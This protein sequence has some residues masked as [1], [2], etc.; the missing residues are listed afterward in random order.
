MTLAEP[1]LPR[2]SRKSGTSRFSEV[3]LIADPLYGYIEITRRRAGETSE[4][5]LILSPW[6]QR[7][8]R[9]R[10]LQS[11][12]WVFPSA[13][14]SRYVHLLGA[15]HLASMF[16]RRIDTSLRAAFSDAP[17][18]ACVEE[19]LRIAGLLH[20]VGHGPF[21]HFFDQ[22][23][24]HQWKINHEDIGRQII[25]DHL[26]EI[27]SSLRSSPSGRFESGESIDPMWV[28]WVMADAEIPGYKPPAWLKACKP[29][30]CGPATVDN[31]DYVPRD[32]HMCG[33][34]LG[35]VDI[36]RLIHYTFVSDKGLVLHSHASGALEMFLASRLYMYTQVYLHRTQRRLDL[37]MREIF[38]DTVKL[39]LPE[40]PLDNLAEYQRLTDW[41]LLNTVDVWMYA[42]PGSDE[43]RLAEAWHRIVHLDLE[44]NL[45]FETVAHREVNLE[46]VEV[47]I[48]DAL[49]QGINPDDVQID[50]ASAT[51]AP[52]NPMDEDGFVAIYDPLSGDIERTRTAEVMSRL[53]QYNRMIRVFTKDKTRLQSLH[54]AVR[55]AMKL[56]K[57]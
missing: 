3:T 34:S 13:E 19:T 22:T 57:P 1:E 52:Q 55:G 18:P 40:N 26:A 27:I 36:R 20:D 45:A 46:A 37:S 35:P 23:W 32:A 28:S 33:V 8:R 51:V 4:Q 12:G 44:W 42:T 56:V 10:Q 41:N 50:V 21:G 2:R 11:A 15:M 47:A 6:L 30:L 29:V 25:S 16:A 39:I 17:S 49:P 43:R 38:A 24:L 53:P 48:R 5:D 9:I 7:L 54:D 14:H 31:L